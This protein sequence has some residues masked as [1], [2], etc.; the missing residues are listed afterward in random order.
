[1]PMKELLDS[2]VDDIVATHLRRIQHENAEIHEMSERLK[3]I[4]DEIEE[5]MNDR[6]D[7]QELGKL[8]RDYDDT[9]NSEELNNYHEIYVSGVKDGVR[10][11][12]ELGVVD[13]Y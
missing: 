4:C 2:Y 11:L 9:R 7:L 5:F 6:D 10:L 13:E 3:E 12:K 1:M 8:L